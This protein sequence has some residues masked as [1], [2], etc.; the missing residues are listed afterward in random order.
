MRQIKRSVNLSPSGVAEAFNKERRLRLSESSPLTLA[1]ASLCSV[2]LDHPPAP[3][4]P[5]TA[6]PFSPSSLHRLAHETAS[7]K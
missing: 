1:V 2:L 7:V 3:A 5:S 4:V 6:L